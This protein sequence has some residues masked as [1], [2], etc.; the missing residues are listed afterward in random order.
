M[1]NVLAIV[2]LAAVITVTPT[3][4]AGATAASP[5][6]P[7]AAQGEKH[8]TAKQERW[9]ARAIDRILSGEK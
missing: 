9:F 6:A 8:L 2:A 3:P 7:Y 4:P 5:S 1:L